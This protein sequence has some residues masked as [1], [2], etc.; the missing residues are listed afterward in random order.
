MSFSEKIRL[1][2]NEN[3]LSQEELADRLGVSRQTVS[4]WELGNAYPEIDKLIAISNIYQVSIDYLLKDNCI[5]GRVKYE[6]ID[7]AL[8]QFLGASNDMEE[9]SQ[10][11]ISILK[12]G[13]IDE[14]EKTEL[15]KI[16][17]T[18]DEISANIERIKK[19]LSDESAV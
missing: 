16:M 14:R 8:I 12:D 19:I 9:I 15:E 3:R 7:R 17:L 10:S 13:V 2:R 6:S 11:L 5:S 1:I 4:K 18:L